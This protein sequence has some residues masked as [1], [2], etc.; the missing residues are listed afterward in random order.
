VRTADE[1]EIR[2][3]FQLHLLTDPSPPRRFTRAT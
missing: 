1:L 3:S 2:V